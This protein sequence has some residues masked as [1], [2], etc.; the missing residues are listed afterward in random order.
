MRDI[1]HEFQL[2]TTG[3]RGEQW[4]LEGYDVRR[5]A[6]ITRIVS[7]GLDLGLSEVYIL[8]V[9][10][11]YTAHVINLADTR[12]VIPFPSLGL[13]RLTANHT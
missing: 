3:R 11:V 1:L 7:S 5:R 12:Y 6:G 10:L 4:S 2:T 8:L 13:H 9:K